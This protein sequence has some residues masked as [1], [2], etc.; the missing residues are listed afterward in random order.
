ML[1]NTRTAILA[2]RRTPQ[3]T[4]DP[5]RVI[6]TRIGNSDR[7][8]HPAGGRRGRRVDRVRVY[9]S[10]ARWVPPRLVATARGRVLIREGPT[11]LA[12]SGSRGCRPMMLASECRRGPRRSGRRRAE[13]FAHGSILRRTACR[14]RTFPARER[15]RA[16]SSL[17]S[18]ATTSNPSTAAPRDTASARAMSTASI[19]PDAFPSG[20]ADAKT[21][22]RWASSCVVSDRVFSRRSA[23]FGA[24]GAVVESPR[25]NG[26]SPAS[27]PPRMDLGWRRSHETSPTTRAVSSAAAHTSS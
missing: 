19:V 5:G 8:V 13:F 23:T 9:D 16:S 18:C 26:T 1:G 7:A 4:F 22:R 6:V 10:T 11:P 24:D 2:Y 25:G 12:R 15:R 17:A 21:S 27:A 14:A 3:R 20:S